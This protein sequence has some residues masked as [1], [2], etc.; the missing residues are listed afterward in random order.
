MKIKPLI[1]HP[2]LPPF[3]PQLK[4]ILEFAFDGGVRSLEAAGYKLGDDLVNDDAHEHF[5][6]GLFSSFGH[7]QSVVGM[8]FI[9]LEK[10]RRELLEQIKA[11]SL[12]KNPALQDSLKQLEAV[13]NRQT[14][15]RRL[16]DGVLWVLL[17]KVWIARHLAFQNTVS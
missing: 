2:K 6:R 11:M 13:E 14:I 8:R 1:E 15:F 7:A 5:N 17:P 3:E 4:A 10:L 16:M 9:E 12:G